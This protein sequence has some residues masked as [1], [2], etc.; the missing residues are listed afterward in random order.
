[1]DKDIQ[2]LEY[3][4]SC[5]VPVEFI[6]W[7]R[8][9]H[10]MVNILKDVD[11]ELRSNPPMIMTLDK[12][13]QQISR[14]VMK[15]SNKDR[16]EILSLF[17]VIARWFRGR[18][19]GE[20]GLKEAFE[21][22][23]SLGAYIKDARVGPNM[24][25]HEYETT[26]I[27]PYFDVS[28][29]ANRVRENREYVAVTKAINNL[30]KIT[31]SDRVRVITFDLDI[32][33]ATSNFSVPIRPTEIEFFEK[34]KLDV[35][36]PFVALLYYPPGSRE[37]EVK[38]RMHTGSTEK[39][40]DTWTNLVAEKLSKRDKDTERSA[41]VMAL[42]RYRKILVEEQRRIN[43]KQGINSTEQEIEDEQEAI[44][45][46]A[47]EENVPVARVS[48]RRIVE[49]KEVFAKLTYDG[50]MF[51]L[52]VPEDVLNNKSRK[53]L[54]K[55]AF[56][57]TGAAPN[58]Q[59]ILTSIKASFDVFDVAIGDRPALLIHCIATDPYLSTLFYV[60]EMEMSTGEKQ[61]LS[62][63]YDGGADK[64][65]MITFSSFIISKPATIFRKN[66]KVMGFFN[67]RYFRVNLS[68][69]TSHETA[70]EIREMMMKLFTI[71]LERET[72]MIKIYNR[73]FKIDFTPP[74]HEENDD[75]EE[76]QKTLD[77]AK[78]YDPNFRGQGRFHQSRSQP[79]P[80]TTWERLHPS[81]DS[82]I[83][84]GK[85]KTE[86]LRQIAEQKLREAASR[87]TTKGTRMDIL[88]FR[89]VFWTSWHPSQQYLG[90]K[91]TASTRFIKL[92]S[93]FAISGAGIEEREPVQGYE[94]LPNIFRVRDEEKPLKIET[95]IK[96]PK[97]R[98]KPITTM[99]IVTEGG[100]GIVTGSIGAILSR[101]NVQKPDQVAVDRIY[102]RMGIPFTAEALIHCACV[103]LN[104]D[105]KGEYRLMDSK[106]REEY[107]IHVRKEELPKF[108]MCCRQEMYDMTTEDIVADMRSTG[109]L[110]P[111]KYYRAIEEWMAEK[112]KK[113]TGKD[114]TFK[115]FI[116][117]KT[118]TQGMIVAVPRHKVM[119]IRD[120]EGNENVVCVLLFVHKGQECNNA[121]HD[122]T[123]LIISDIREARKKA[124]KYV[125]ESP[126]LYKKLLEMMKNNT[127]VRRI[128][129]AEILENPSVSLVS[130]PHNIMNIQ[131]L[132]SPLLIVTQQ[133][134]TYGKLRAMRLLDQITNTSVV[135]TT[136]PLAPICVAEEK[137]LGIRND[138]D[139]ALGIL[140]RLKHSDGNVVGSIENDQY[141]G[142]H[143]YMSGL[144]DP[145]T[146]LVI[147][148]S[149]TEVSD[150][151]EEVKGIRF[152]DPRNT[153]NT[154][155][156]LDK[157]Q[158]LKRALTRILRHV[159]QTYV[160]AREAGSLPSGAEHVKLTC[161]IVPD[162]QYVESTI[163]DGK[164]IL[165]SQEA[166]DWMVRYVDNFL[167]K[168]RRL[169]INTLAPPITPI[170]RYIL[171]VP[172]IDMLTELQDYLNYYEPVLRPFFDT[173][174]L[175]ET[176]Q[177]Y[178]FVIEDELL[179]IQ[180]INRNSREGLRRNA[181][182][183]AL[184]C[185]YNWEV[186]KVNT[187][188]K[189]LLSTEMKLGDITEDEIT[190]EDTTLPVLN[191]VASGLPKPL[192]IVKVKEMIEG[193]TR[194]VPIEHDVLWGALLSFGRV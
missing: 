89:G 109:W 192:R 157:L 72:E 49:A 179:C 167:A 5:D 85:E 57:R 66:G 115:I 146:C 51:S 64:T 90:F 190:L 8:E 34:V 38:S 69:V 71:Y 23:K 73:M 128:E 120:Y 1:M 108:A 42:V 113:R 193:E 104:L 16:Y 48:R 14:L 118:D 191:V 175:N 81:E 36:L 3:S 189:T 95:E 55:F 9:R 22:V 68:K 2:R 187:G 130:F 96:I 84:Y 135:I 139:T 180:M 21:A 152:Y 18:K 174:S 12:Q 166:Y 10:T 182:D 160:K 150:V 158:L 144:I 86:K 188:F 40:I 59:P 80:I 132:F 168:S 137:L 30:N 79:R 102:L 171:N 106:E 20:E 25:A 45:E 153:I 184:S 136:P 74:I 52:K 83:R 111:R 92:P 61:R 114:K 172:T 185:A 6:A 162:Y 39:D 87:K 159:E 32:N 62:L 125:F 105:S 88:L 77:L 103:A 101:Y 26:I 134:D 35:D 43:A 186:Y 116:I 31:T 131:S 28:Q 143:L 53:I 11:E 170:G 17:P 122:Q 194:D 145:I 41:F 60:N 100:V 117:E 176:E 163:I 19:Q 44:L 126:V 27:S 177:P 123:E 37:R 155:S 154:I 82:F 4:V 29:I 112:E 97:S 147:P 165:D 33:A 67:R 56:E 46:E 142:L 129:H 183:I 173:Q 151:V 149:T 169:P 161:I 47:E 156:E 65:A 75:G 58:T 124:R 110:D 99:K 63:N 178:F 127:L 50:R 24:S 181:R 119:H 13:K 164:A 78:I 138:Y 70:M 148:I 93:C 98:P 76:N 140:R 94:D 15:F 91:Q 141:R 54:E 7:D 107:V 121:A 133:L